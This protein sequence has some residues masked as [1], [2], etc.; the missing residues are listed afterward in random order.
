MQSTG[1]FTELIFN[2]MKIE[3]SKS[4]INFNFFHELRAKHNYLFPNL[5]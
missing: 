2:K 5:L 1:Q 4:Y 3:T